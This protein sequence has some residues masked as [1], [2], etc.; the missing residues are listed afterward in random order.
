[1]VSQPSSETGRLRSSLG[2]VRGL[3]SAKEG[4]HH[5]WVQRLTSVA[6][7][8]LLLWFVASLVG[9]V[10]ADYASFVG[11]LRRPLNT[12]LMTALLTAGF[13][14]LQLGLQVIIEDYVHNT[15]ASIASNVVVKFAIALLALGGIFSILKIAFGG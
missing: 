4:A 15:A 2:R 7:V 6:L 1:M 13:W 12:I 10:G 9:L 8:P 3:G 11:W 5:W 14:H